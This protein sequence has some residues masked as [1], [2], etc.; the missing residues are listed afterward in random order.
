[1]NAERARLLR[2]RRLEKIRDIAKQT[3]ARDAAEAE[4]TLAQLHA[5]CERTGRLAGEYA[6]RRD[7]EQ[8]DALRQQLR[9]V[10][11][12]EAIRRNTLDE[13][14]RA[15]AIADAKLRHLATA[16]R[17][18]AAVDDRAQAQE[19]LIARGREAPALHGRKPSGTGL[20]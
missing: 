13:M 12:L 16:E 17:R 18:R 9:F 2:L 3:A 1:M 5:L 8:G 7:A 14:R 4:G 11:G 20:E 10:D 19:R 15:E 6:A